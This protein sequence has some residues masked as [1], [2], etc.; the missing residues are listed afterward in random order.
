[1]AWWDGLSEEE[2]V[3]MEQTPTSHL[4]LDGNEVEIHRCMTDGA[5]VTNATMASKLHVGHKFKQPVCLTRQEIENLVK[6]YIG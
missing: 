5:I 6:G 3:R 4:V 2:I 1:M